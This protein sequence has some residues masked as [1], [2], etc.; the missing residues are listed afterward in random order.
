VAEPG[1]AAP[2]DEHLGR[3]GDVD[4]LWT[5]G[6]QVSQA[7]TE[8]VAALYRDLG[9]AARRVVSQDLDAEIGEVR[10]DLER[11]ADLSF[12]VLDRFLG[13]VRRVADDE[14]TRGAHP[15]EIVV[16]GAIAGTT[17]SA[18][19]WLHNV[20]RDEHPA[21]I[22]HLGALTTVNGASIDPS[23]ITVTASQAPID[24]GHSRRVTLSVEVPPF[25]PA[26]RYHGV[27]VTDGTVEQAML[28]QLEVVT[29]PSGNGRDD[30][31]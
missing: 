29:P 9:S 17:A 16:L 22:L 3:N 14:E 24:G 13:V 1:D 4:D 28:V 25:A 8:R 11:L 19:V 18:D 15:R 20:S 5:F 10:L 6:V 7:M 31:S 23:R 26:G 27:L 12:D 2:S 30:P 21:P